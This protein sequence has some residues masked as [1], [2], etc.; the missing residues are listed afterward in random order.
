MKFW[1]VNYCCHGQRGFCNLLIFNK[2]VN[3]RD[4]GRFVWLGKC[5]YK[6]CLCPYLTEVIP[7][8]LEK[9][10]KI[11]LSLEKPKRKTL[12]PYI[13]LLQEY[14]A[15]LNIRDSSDH[16]WTYNCMLYP[17][18]AIAYRQKPCL[19]S[20]HEALVLAELIILYTLIFL[21]SSFLICKGVV[22][23]LVSSVI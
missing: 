20:T 17:Q 16:G 7:A 23:I 2:D 22:M 19:R 13:L 1:F 3:Y 5:L 11:D 10:S 18:H 4:E 21:S 12:Y 14:V 8:Y 15:L 9:A 6:F